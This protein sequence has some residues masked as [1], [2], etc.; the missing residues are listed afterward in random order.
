MSTFNTWRLLTKLSQTC[1]AAFYCFISIPLFYA[2][3]NLGLLIMTAIDSGLLLAF[4][5]IAVCV[6]KPLSFLNCSVIASA[7]D[8]AD[9]QTASA[10]AQSLHGNI[11]LS[12]ARLGLEKW[13]AS[14]KMNCYETKSIWGMSI[15]LCIL[16]SCS[17]MILPTL[18]F[19]ARKSGA[20]GKSVV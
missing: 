19:K 8:A 17:V 4:I 20:G 1:I 18:W 7:S 2:R 3:A 15:G 13:A 16:F 14:T 10:F 5:I 9:A 11:N 12:G 6:G